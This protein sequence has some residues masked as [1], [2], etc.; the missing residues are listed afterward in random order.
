MT[1]KLNIF[2]L[3]LIWVMLFL[4]IIKNLI[5]WTELINYRKVISSNI[6]NLMKKTVQAGDIISYIPIKKEFTS[7][8]FYKNLARAA[9]RR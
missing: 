8:D 3:N 6:I 7:K 4:R 2:H 9:Y 1:N 5:S